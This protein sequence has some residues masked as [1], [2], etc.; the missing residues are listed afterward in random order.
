MLRVPMMRQ[1]AWRRGIH[2]HVVSMVERHAINL[3]WL[4]SAIENILVASLRQEAP[5]HDCL[6]RAAVSFVCCC[7]A[8]CALMVLAVLAASADEIRPAY[9]ELREVALG[10]F[11]VLWQT[12]MV[13]D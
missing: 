1:S 8:A 3:W 10:E 11:N 7:A 5:H 6:F 4:P 12:P 9:L 2:G 13:G